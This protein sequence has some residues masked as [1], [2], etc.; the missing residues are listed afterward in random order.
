M[1]RKSEISWQERLVSAERLKDFQASVAADLAQ[2]I[3]GLEDELCT[4]SPAGAAELKKKLRK[5]R[6]GM[7]SLPSHHSQISDLGLH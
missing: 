5:H 2:A 1:P 6:S 4:A 3:A 7:S